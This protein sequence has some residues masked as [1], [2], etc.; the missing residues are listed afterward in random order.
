[1]DSPASF[2]PNSVDNA[3]LSGGESGVG[4]RVL[5]TDAPGWFTSRFAAAPH[6]EVLVVR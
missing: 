5:S 6:A 1:M 4:S 2:L 3:V